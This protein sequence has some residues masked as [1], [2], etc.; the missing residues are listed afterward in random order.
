MF[1]KF[2]KAAI[3]CN[4]NYLFELTWPATFFVVRI[5]IVVVL[6][7][8]IRVLLLSSPKTWFKRTSKF[9]LEAVSNYLKMFPSQVL[10]KKVPKTSKCL[11]Y[12]MIRSM[13]RIQK[14]ADNTVQEKLSIMPKVLFWRMHSHFC[15]EWT[16]NH[17]LRKSQ[18][19]SWSLLS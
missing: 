11:D 13:Q 1:S 9:L 4:I 12:S 10:K 7:K 18:K 8:R 14:M 17:T 16:S 6:I 15:L 2:N 19:S 5:K 3:S